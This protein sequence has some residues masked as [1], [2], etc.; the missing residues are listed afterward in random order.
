MRLIS[1]KEVCFKTS[2]SRASIYRK[3]A[4]GTF[5]HYVG[6]G[7]RTPNSKGRLTGRI[8]WLEAK[9]DEWIAE[10]IKKRTP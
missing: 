2:L 8:G 4:E 9:V 5:P 6:L 10:R 3:V 1:L 7:K